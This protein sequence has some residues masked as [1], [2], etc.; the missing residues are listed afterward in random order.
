MPLGSSVS[1]LFSA[2]GDIRQAPNRRL[3]LTWLAAAAAGVAALVLSVWWLST[4]IAPLALNADTRLNEFRGVSA[5]QLL[6]SDDAPLAGLRVQ[7]DRLEQDI[8]PAARSVGSLARLSPALSWLPGLGHELVTWSVQMDPSYGRPGRPNADS[9]LVRLSRH[10]PAGPDDATQGQS[11]RV[12]HPTDLSYRR[13]QVLFC[14]RG[15]RAE[16]SIRGRAAKGARVSPTGLP[17]CDHVACR[18]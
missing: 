8:A 15:Q 1:D 7:V 5:S 3:S 2:V 17:G 6:Q 11:S 16:P 12:C 9:R 18:D 4:E 14:V 13:S 10:L